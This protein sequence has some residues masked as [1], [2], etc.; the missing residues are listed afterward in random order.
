MTNEYSKNTNGITIGNFINMNIKDPIP[1]DFKEYATTNPMYMHEYGYY[2]DSQR[3]G[4]LY[5]PIIGIASTISAQTSKIITEWD[6]K[7]VD[8][9]NKLT[10]HKLRWF[11]R[12]ANKNAAKYFGEHYGV[13]W[14]FLDHPIYIPF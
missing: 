10:T 8:N 14:T 5:L 9:K 2:M 7:A 1:D 12:R 11:E 6:G 3:F 13:E 4:M